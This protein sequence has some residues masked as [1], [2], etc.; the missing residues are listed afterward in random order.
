MATYAQALLIAIPFFMVLIL[1]ELLYATKKNKQ[2]YSTIDTIASLS[3]GVSNSIKNLLGLGVLLISYPY[4]LEQ[5]SIVKLDN[6]WWVWMVAFIFIDFAG[7]WS[8]RISHN[9]NLFWNNHIIHHSSEHFN[10]ACALRQPISDVIRYYPLLLLPAAILGVPEQLIA[11]IAPLHLFLQFWYHTEHIGKLGWLEYVF[12]TPSQHRVHHAINAPY[13]DKNLGQIFSFWDRLFGTF[14]EELD[15]EPPRYG[16]LKAVQTWNPIRINFLH[17]IQLIT[18][19]YRTSSYWDKLRIWFM[20]TGWR[21]VDVT[22]AYPIE[23]IEDIHGFERYDTKPSIFFRYY[24]ILQ[25]V[26][27]LGL[28]I[29]MLRGYTQLSHVEL[30]FFSVYL[31]TTIYGYSDLFDLKYSG[32]VIELIRSCFGL[33]FLTLLNHWSGLQAVL[34]PFK[35]LIA[36]YLMLT[37]LGSMYIVA[38]EFKMTKA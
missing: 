38:V 23:Y 2:T 34:D 27:V 29:L 14:Q 4:L 31:G 20:P 9:I 15:D 7:Y 17:L 22:D 5:L 25:L 16:V 3:S 33:W 6:Q 28:F 13:I 11:Y 1:I 18:D 30:I 37:L 21:P 10:L 26:A 24:A 32:Y 12:I 36:L 19:A 35:G 8:H